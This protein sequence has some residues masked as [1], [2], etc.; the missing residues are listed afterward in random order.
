MPIELNITRPAKV[1]AATIHIYCKVR[2]KFTASIKD[3]DGN[4][5]CGQED[6]YVWDLMPGQHY[7]D[8]VILD[9][10]LVTGQVLNWETPT[11]EQI[12][13]LVDT[14]KERK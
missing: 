12:Q 13:E 14:L 2:D 5:I 10:D 1:Q 11:A 9:I 3:T 6:G 7:G 4:E 8:Y